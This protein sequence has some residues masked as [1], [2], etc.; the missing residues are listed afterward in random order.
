MHIRQGV[1]IFLIL[2]IPSEYERTTTC[3]VFRCVNDQNQNSISKL[4]PQRL[5]SH[6][7][8]IES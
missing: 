1:I 4:K 7:S 5:I 8:H 2:K 3:S 6:H